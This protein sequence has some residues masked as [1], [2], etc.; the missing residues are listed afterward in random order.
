MSWKRSII[1]FNINALSEISLN[2]KNML[3]YILKNI[4][5]PYYYFLETR[6]NKALI[7]QYC[8]L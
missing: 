8:F 6:C 5:K 7:G 3:I 2:K 1:K 4:E